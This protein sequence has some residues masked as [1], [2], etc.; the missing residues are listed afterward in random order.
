ML[1]DNFIPVAKA[2]IRNLFFMITVLAA[3]WVI[4]YLFFLPTSFNEA[5]FRYRLSNA[6]SSQKEII[7]FSEL[8]AF[9]WDEVCA[10]HPYNGDFHYPKYDRTYHAPDRAAH[11]GFW[12]L[13]FIK[14]DGSPSYISG[15]CVR[16]GAAIAEFGCLSRS[17]AIFRLSEAKA[18]PVYTVTVPPR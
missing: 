5:L 16:G 12:T 14:H 15:T 7:R 2:L 8:A 9:E 4:W 18:C 11:D 13:L 1:V 17:Q 3:G 6:A 10:H